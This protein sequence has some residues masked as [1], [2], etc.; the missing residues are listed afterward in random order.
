MESFAFNKSNTIIILFDLHLKIIK[1][2]DWGYYSN[3]CSD[4]LQVISDS[5]IIL[6]KIMVFK[7]LTLTMVMQ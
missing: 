6:R 2:K 5:E 1:Q 3:Y 4:G 7:L